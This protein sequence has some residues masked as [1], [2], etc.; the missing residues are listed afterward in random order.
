M[1]FFLLFF[2]CCCRCWYTEW[3]LV[4]SWKWASM[5]SEASIT[6]MYSKIA[7]IIEP[8]EYRPAPLTA[9]HNDRKGVAFLCVFD[10]C[11]NDLISRRMYRIE[12]TRKKRK[13]FSFQTIRDRQRQAK[14]TAKNIQR[15]SLFCWLIVHRFRIFISWAP[16]FHQW[17]REK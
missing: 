3:V 5:Q 16:F 2:R 1:G 10:L 4:C 12:E 8:C 17:I 11:N 6:W 13:P 7:N 14:I 15:V 9:A